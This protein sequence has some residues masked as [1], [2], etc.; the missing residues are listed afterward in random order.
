MPVP[1]PEVLH[2]MVLEYDEKSADTGYLCVVDLKNSQKIAL[3]A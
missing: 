3:D 1:S 2:E